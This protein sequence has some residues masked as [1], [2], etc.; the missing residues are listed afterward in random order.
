MIENVDR[1]GAEIV[2]VG[3]GLA[4]LA[5][6]RRLHEAGRSFVICEAAD[7]VGGRVA[8][9]DCEG[10]RLDRGF[11]VLLTAYPE[12][13]RLLD[14]RALDLRKFY[15]GAQVRFGGA[16]H[17]VADPFRHPVDG[18]RGAFSPIGSFGDKLRVGSLRLRNFDLSRHGAGL[19]SLAALQAEGFSESIIER[20][21]RP[22]LGGVF[23]ENELSTAVEKFEFVMRSFAG[24]ETAVPARG[25]G[26]IPRQLA[27]NLP[28]SA[29]RLGMRVAALEGN[30]VRLDDGTLL[31]CRAVV[32]AT[33][34]REFHRLLEIPSPE[35]L[36][37][38]TTC[39]YFSAPTSPWHEPIILLNGDGRGPI[40]HAAVMTAVSHDLAPEGRH[41]IAVNVV[42][43]MALAAPDLLEQVRRQLL[44]WFGRSSENWVHLRSYSIADAVPR[45]ALVSQKSPRLREGVYL[46]G[47]HCGIASL[48]TA[49]ASGWAAAEAV[50]QDLA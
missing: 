49:L 29:V 35:N 8:T 50:L 34:Q 13:Q 44:E 30:G 38:S 6:G 21:F 26:E 7:R 2:I 42:D 43:R 41:L 37:N 17:R 12:A 3:G 40:N 45:Q 4:G 20:F 25:M 16:W 28:S 19:A 24:G 32:L 15:P 47:D 23:L 14:Y 33:E 1:R 27:A 39:F 10:F 46:C 11:Q 31:A 48:N 9:D 5:C 18:L 22:F 36:S